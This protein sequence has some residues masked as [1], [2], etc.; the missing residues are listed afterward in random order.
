MTEQQQDKKL[1]KAAE[2]SITSDSQKQAVHKII[3]P[4][5][6]KNSEGF[7]ES[8]KESFGLDE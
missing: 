1:G 8:F 6:K 3:N 2:V 5:T 7:H 4:E